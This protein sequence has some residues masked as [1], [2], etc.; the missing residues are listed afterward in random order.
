ME[1][2]RGAFRLCCVKTCEVFGALS[3]FEPS[4]KCPTLQCARGR[5][6]GKGWTARVWLGT[7]EFQSARGI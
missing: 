7:I 2:V 1:H 6:A 5:G 4:L 3:F